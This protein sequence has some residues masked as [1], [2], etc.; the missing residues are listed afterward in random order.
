M[1]GGGR[2]RRRRRRM[3]WRMK[4]R[5]RRRRRL[6]HRQLLQHLDPRLHHRRALRVIPEGEIRLIF[7]FL[8]K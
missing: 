2:M 5:R 1:R 8:N 3:K 4:R 6:E 7:K